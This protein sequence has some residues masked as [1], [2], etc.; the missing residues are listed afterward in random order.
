VAVT[1]RGKEVMPI[2]RINK[3]AKAHGTYVPRTRETGG[4]TLPQY[5]FGGRR[6]RKAIIALFLLGILVIPAMAEVTAIQGYIDYGFVMNG[7][8]VTNRTYA[9][10]DLNAKVDD[11]NNTY[12]RFEQTGATSDTTGV[13]RIRYAYVTTNVAGILGL[14]DSGIGITTSLG[15]R[16]VYDKGY[17][18]MLTR[19]LID[20]T[21]ADVNIGFSMGVEVNLMKLVTI[22]AY[23]DPFQDN[24]FI[25]GAFM[26]Q[27]IGGFPLNLEVWMAGERRTNLSD[28]DIIFSGEFKPS[29]GSIAMD[30]GFGFKY[31]MNNN[32]WM[33]DVGAGAVINKLITLRA[34][35][36]GNSTNIVDLISVE[37]WAGKFAELITIKGE[38]Y[39][40]LS[41]TDVFRGFDACAELA[42]KALTLRAGYL[43]NP[44]YGGTASNVHAYMAPSQPEG[45]MYLRGMITWK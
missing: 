27:K 45:G 24:D 15:W 31:S 19:H 30:T 3:P 16:D 11:F 12:F 17:D 33:F 37:V 42:L 21:S 25:I 38:A 1:P 2:D 43:Y 6:M 34:F 35:L 28:A 44:T 41:K 23:D 9:R 10:F 29:F 36:N 14:G 26:G 18:Y 22:A 13:G 8:Q 39:I 7:T 32:T 20:L 4:C 40:Q 5:S